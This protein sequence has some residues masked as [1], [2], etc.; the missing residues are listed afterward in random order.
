MISLGC[1]SDTCDCNEG[2]AGLG[3]SCI[4]YDSDGTTCLLQGS[5]VSRSCVYGTDSFGNCL[6]APATAPIYGGGVPV[7]PGGGS[8]GGTNWASI[9]APITQLLGMRYGVPQ[10]NAGQSITQTPLGY[11]VTQQPAGVAA[12]GGSISLGGATNLSSLLPILLIGGL[13]LFAFKSISK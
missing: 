7:F 9:F 1:V 12:T 8:A 5:D 2:L 11:Q 6:P 4:L 13:A 3:D 10:L